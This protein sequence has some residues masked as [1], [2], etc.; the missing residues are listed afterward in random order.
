VLLDQR[1]LRGG[2]A[3]GE[4]AEPE[5]LGPVGTAAT[6]PQDASPNLAVGV[7]PNACTAAF[8]TSRRAVRHLMPFIDC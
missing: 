7:A 5:R 2:A 4:D 3:T 8:A 6:I 1:T